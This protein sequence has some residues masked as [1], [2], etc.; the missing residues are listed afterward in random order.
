[1]L[2]AIMESFRYSEVFELTVIGEK[3]I[4]RDAEGG[5][6]W[7][8][9]R[10]LRWNMR[11]GSMMRF[12]SLQKAGYGRACEVHDDVFLGG[13]DEELFEDSLEKAKNIPPWPNENVPESEIEEIFNDAKLLFG[14]SCYACEKSAHQ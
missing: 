4:C 11:H 10:R 14:T 12:A 5:T 8:R 1:M 7:G 6:S 3:L 13:T 9:A 2:V